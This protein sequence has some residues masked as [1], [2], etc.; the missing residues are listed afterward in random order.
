MISAA[1]PAADVPVSATPAPPLPL[2][3]ETTDVL[4][5]RE[6]EPLLVM[7]NERIERLAGILKQAVDESSA[8][9]V[10]PTA[11]RT[12]L[13]LEMIG[14]RLTMVPKPTEADRIRIEPHRRRFEAGKDALRAETVRIAKSASLCAQLTSVVAPLAAQREYAVDG[15]SIVLANLLS[16]LRLQVELYK[17][18]HRDLQPDFRAHGWGQLLSATDVGGGLDTSGKRKYGP[19]LKSPPRN[20]L[21][22]GSGIL[23]VRGQ[24]KSGFRHTDPKFGFVFDLTSG[25]LWALDADGSIFDETM[26]VRAAAD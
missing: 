1:S 9:A 13:E 3:L 7:A 5:I 11:E 15:K 4:A 20:P 22:G 14:I 17:L 21:T 23:L 10:R 18:E 16:T 12:Y 19:Y 8:A 24:P 25:R 26:S 6:G 2:P